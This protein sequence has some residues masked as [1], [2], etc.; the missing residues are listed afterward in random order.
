MSTWNSDLPDFDGDHGDGDG[1]L[2]MLSIRTITAFL[3]GFGWIGA[4]CLSSG[5][6]IIL[7]LIIGGGVG[8]ILMFMVFSIMRFF[9]NMQE[10]GTLDYHNA[11]GQIATVY[12]PIPANGTAPGQVEVM[13][14][15]R[16]QVVRA[17]TS[18]PDRIENRMSVLVIDLNEDN[19]LQVIP[20]ESEI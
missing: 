8:L 3:V 19:S 16:L 4:A 2:S 14:Q 10:E 18:K 12:L 13:I 1:G 6:G 7:T 15:G 11:V 20:D 9:Y 5:M 17:F